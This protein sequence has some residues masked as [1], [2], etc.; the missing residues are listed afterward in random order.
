MFYLKKIWI[1]VYLR[2]FLVVLVCVLILID[3]YNLSLFPRGR[4]DIENIGSIGGWISGMFTGVAII[5]AIESLK[6][7]KKDLNLKY[8]KDD[9]KELENKSKVYSWVKTI[10]DPVHKNIIDYELTMFN[11]LKTP[12]YSWKVFI[13]KHEHVNISGDSYGLVMPKDKISLKLSSLL[14][15]SILE[16]V[17]LTKVLFETE[18]GTKVIR[19]HY[20]NVKRV[21][22]E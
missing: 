10:K 14:D 8:E 18:E 5:I 15:V 6:T 16:E 2:W 11:D 22:D 3:Y 13:I 12:L 1:S 20:G 7:T 21:V 19:D 4:V 17:V 9:L